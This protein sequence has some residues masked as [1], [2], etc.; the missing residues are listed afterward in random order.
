MKRFSLALQFLTIFPVKVSSDIKEKDFGASLLYFPIIGLLIGILLSLIL[1]LFSF[2]PNL[3]LSA[4]I[5]IVAIT[6][7]GVIHLDGFADTCDGFY[8][9]KPKEEILRI[10]RDSRIGVMGVVG[11]ISLLILKYSLIASIPRDLLWKSLIMMTAFSRW[12]Q[13]LACLISRYARREGKAKFFIEYTRKKDIIIGALFIFGL[14]LFLARLK[15]TLI[16]IAS[17]LPTLLFIEYVK[18]KIGGMTG[19]TIGATSEIAEVSTLFF[20]LAF[21][22]IWN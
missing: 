6:V 14:F 19:D 21:S 7:T 12:S 10:M 2:L 18:R 15:G 22:S 4:L 5:L 1:F 3:V 17:F 20:V 9:N 11:I 8:G 16:F 13:G